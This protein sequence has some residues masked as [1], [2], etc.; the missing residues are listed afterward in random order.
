VS[1]IIALDYGEKRIGVAI[2]DPLGIIATGLTSVPDL[3]E[4]QKTIAQYPDAVE[5][6]VGLPK[7]MKGELGSSAQKVLEFIEQLKQVCSLPVKTLDERLTTVEAER[8]LLETGLSR[9]KRKKVIDQSAAAV[10]LQN[11]LNNKK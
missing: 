7:T 10:L 9:A 4:L 8:A 1:R 3:A 2:S 11:Y 5:I 6:I